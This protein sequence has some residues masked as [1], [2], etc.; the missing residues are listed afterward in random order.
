MPARLAPGIREKRPGYFE[1]RVYGGVDPATGKA[2]Q[3]SRTVRGSVKDANALRAQLL[4]EVE[5]KG[6]GGTTHTV[7]EL[8]EAVIDHLEALGREPTTLIGYRQIA[9]RFESRLGKVPL[10]KL[11]A[12]HL[13]AFYGELA[14]GGS[15]PARVRRYHA[16][17][18]RCLAQGVRWE[19]VGDNVAARASPPPEPR[20]QLDVP[21]ADAVVALLEAAVHSRQPELA[22]AFRLLAALGGRRGEVCGLQWRDFDFT[23]RIC[24]I[25]R[26]VKHVADRVVVGDAKNHQQRVLQLDAPTVEVM[27]RHRQAMEER[28]AFCRTMLLPDA[29][30]LSDEPDG[31]APWK[32]NRL[33][34]ALTRLRERSGYTGRLHDLR[35]WH[36][37]QLLGAGEAPVVVA[38][39]LGHR[40]PS[41]THRWYA[42]AMPR[43]DVRAAALIGEALARRE[44]QV[45]ADNHKA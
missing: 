43:A 20:R 29:F 25:R 38:E 24:V 9:A 22:V 14:R 42:H 30:I 32:P 41:T 40:D 36:A 10:R 35:H 23:A 17:A 45:T 1:V 16:F 12:S 11:R 18:H 13:D 44:G 4:I 26:A 5:R 39:R 33:T 15:S 27:S 7:A 28:A 19:W 3:L 37:S 6:G 34:Q 8:F 2:R 31:A 21:T